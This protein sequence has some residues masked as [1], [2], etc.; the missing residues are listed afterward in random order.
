MLRLA[1]QN[2]RR[3]GRQLGPVARG[4]PSFDGASGQRPQPPA[5]RRGGGQ[6]PARQEEGAHRPGRRR[7]PTPRACSMPPSPRRCE[8]RSGKMRQRFSPR[9][10]LRVDPRGRDELRQPVADP[11]RSTPWN[12]S[13]GGGPGTASPGW[14]SFVSPPHSHGTMWWHLAPRRRPV[15][16]GMRAAAVPGGDRP[17]QPVGDGA[18]CPADVERL[19]RAAP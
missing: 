6:G 18:G 2:G 12:G 14:T 5:L 19:T 8:I 13:A 11:A 15:A 16:P 4:P 7:S 17:A 9:P 3:R 1:R 10:A